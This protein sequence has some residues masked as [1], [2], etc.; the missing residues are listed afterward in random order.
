MK[1]IMFVLLFAPILVFGTTCDLEKDYQI[2]DERNLTCDAEKRTMTSFST[3]NEEVVVNNEVCKITCTE[4]IVFSI[5]PIKK[6]L[7]GTSFNYPLYASGERKCKATYN[8]N[9]YEQKIRRLVN[10]YASLTGSAKAT[11]ANEITNY[12]ALKKTCDEFTKAGSDFQNKYSYDG[13]VTLKV[14]T[15]TNEVTIPYEFVEMEDYNSV[16]STDEINYSLA[17]NYNEANRTCSNSD[18]TINEWTET[19]RIFGKYTMK[20]T[21]LEMYE[22]DIKDLYS[23][24]TCNAGDR[25][26]T[27]FSELTRPVANDTTDKGY[28]LTLTANNL[29]HNLGTIPGDWSLNVDCWY[30]VKNLIFPQGNSGTNVDDNYDEYGGTAFQYRII[31]LNDPFP[32]REPGAN[33]KGK[34]TI[35]TSTKDNLSSLQRFVISLD[36]SSINRIRE[37]NDTHSYDT[38]NL[39]EMEKSPFV[40]ANPNIIDRK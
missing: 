19:A 24:N 20:D 31:D 15:S 8:Y 21:Y 10:E 3:T 36:R 22:G 27:S 5:D 17:C 7:A 40:E 6:V 11:K 18:K 25:F 26:F 34:E 13:D 1:K 35:I 33:W 30:Q 4:N 2:T 12:Y 39:N 28:K 37:Y 16:V 14:E 23:N 32:E 9:A 38:F 29:G